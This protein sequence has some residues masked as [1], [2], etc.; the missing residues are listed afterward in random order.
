MARDLGALVRSAVE[1]KGRVEALEQK[2]HSLHRTIL[3]K[4]VLQGQMPIRARTAARRSAQ[5]EAQARLR[6]FREASPAYERAIGDADP[7]TRETRVI[8]LDSLRW[9][10]PLA[11]PDDPVLIERALGHQDFPYRVLTQTRE[12]ALGGLMIDIGANIGRMCVPRVILGDVTAAYCA[13]PDSLNYTCLVRNVRDNRLEGLVLPDQVAIGSSNGTARLMRASTAGGHRV[14]DPGAATQHEVVEVESLTLD[15]WVERAGIDLQQLVF[16]KLDAQGSE[17]HVLM[18]APG[19]LACR[20]V[21]WQIEI[22]LPLL[23]KRGFAAEDLF[24][25]LRPHFTH[26]VDLNRSAPGNRV[27]PIAEIAEA[28][29]AVGGG[30]GGRTDVLVFCQEPPS[31]R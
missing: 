4:A 13:E 9:W 30:S 29:A 31:G 26:F 11:R 6:R 22:D 3:D 1:R 16:V 7:R 2:I 8:E 18:G 24:G 10:V 14:L 17:V 21:V 28:L 20:Q 12:L 27:R 23:A 19:V 25:R 15:T 5:P